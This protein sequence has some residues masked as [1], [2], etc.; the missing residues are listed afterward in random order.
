MLHPYQF[1]LLNFLSLWVALQY[2]QDGSLSVIPDFLFSYSSFPTSKFMPYI[3]FKLFLFFYFFFSISYHVLCKIL[4]E[5]PNWFPCL[6]SDTPPVHSQHSYKM[7]VLWHKLAMCH[8]CL[9]T[10]SSFPLPSSF[11]YYHCA[12]TESLTY[13]KTHLLPDILLPAGTK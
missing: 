13:L 4:Q 11:Y 2:I 3:T 5:P 12:D 8:F 6:L 9:N 1:S 7:I 10:I